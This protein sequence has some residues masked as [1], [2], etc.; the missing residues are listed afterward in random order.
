MPQVSMMMG[1]KTDKKIVRESGMAAILDAVGV[2][3]RVDVCSAHRDPEV[4]GPLVRELC[5]E[6]I[7]VFIGIAGLSAALPGALAG[8]TGMVRP[9]IGVPLDVQGLPACTDMPPGVPVLTAGEGGDSEGNVNRKRSLKAA[10]H[11]ACQI[12]AVADDEIM[13]G[14]VG[15]VASTKKEPQLNTTLED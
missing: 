7:K 5:D 8:H 14:L 6:G 2:S 15:Y 9:V 12:L 4:L 3:Y 13:A 11:Q 10:A 1:S